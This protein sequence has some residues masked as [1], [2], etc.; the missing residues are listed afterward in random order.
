MNQKIRLSLLVIMSALLLAVSAC[1]GGEE[2]PQ[3][4]PTVAEAAPAEEEAVEEEPAAEESVGEES[5]EA[6]EPTAEPAAEEEA[7][8]DADA[9]PT[10]EPAEEASTDDATEEAAPINVAFLQPTNNAIIPITST[11][12]MTVTGVTIAPAGEVAEGQVHLHILIN[13]PFIEAGNPIPSDEAHLHFGDGSTT[14]EVA[15]PVGVHTLRL[16]AADGAHVAL[17]G[18][19][20]RDEIT[21]NVTDGA[22]EQAVRFASPEDGA[23]VPASFEVAMAATGLV[24]EPAGPINENAGHFHI[25]IDT[26]FIEPG[27]PIPNDD[28]HLHFGAGQLTT[29][30]ELEPGEHTLR[31][32]MA[33]GVHVAL[34]GEQYRDEITVTVTE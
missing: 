26:D 34:E 22:P 24:V 13:T 2:E 28:S 23:T 21:V 31:L 27:Q 1:G 8:T 7:E 17:E 9:E 32:Q 29:T 3:P 16:Q 4:E 12:I 20:Y 6:E 15:L 11:I 18:D 19:E 10:A 25:L 5:P 14:T 33:D 30:L